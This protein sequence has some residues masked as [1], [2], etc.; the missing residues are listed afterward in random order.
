MEGTLGEVPRD[1]TM[2]SIPRKG[3]DL[4]GSIARSPGKV[5][6]QEETWLCFN[7]VL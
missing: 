6:E 3:I 5:G 4:S 1:Q 7:S 2:D